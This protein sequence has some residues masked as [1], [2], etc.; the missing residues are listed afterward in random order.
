MGQKELSKLL[1]GLVVLV[2]AFVLVM[3]ALVA[4]MLGEEAALVTERSAVRW[5]VT[6]FLW[7]T[8]VP[9][10]AALFLAWRIFGEIGRDNSFC[11]E[12]A[13]RLRSIS[14]LALLDTVVYIAAT[15]VLA[16]VNLLHPGAFLVLAAAILIGSVAT[17]ACAALSHLTRKA[18]ELKSDNDLTI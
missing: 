12:N 14:H 6:V 3:C 4:P 10:F 9:G 8:A 13:M 18:A 16:V 17:V 2:G 1:R 11:L 5:V 7:L 15:V